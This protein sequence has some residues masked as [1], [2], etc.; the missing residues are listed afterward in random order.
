MN[1]ASFWQ[2]SAKRTWHAL[3]FAVLVV[4]GAER[5]AANAASAGTAV[6]IG[7]ALKAD[8]REVWSRLVALSGGTGSKWLVFP[9]AS[10]EPEQS[11]AAIIS[12]LE[13]HGATAVMVPLSARLKSHAVADVVRDARWIEQTRNATGVYFTGGAQE[14]ITTALYDA[15]GKR[16]PL[17][18]AIWELFERGGVVAGSS[19]GAAI[20]SETMFREPRDILTLMREG[21]KRGSDI[22]R[23]LGFVG[24]GVL[25]DQHFIKRGRFGRALAVMAQ[26]K[27]MLGIGVEENSAAVFKGG[28]VEVLGERGVMVADLTGATITAAPLRLTNAKLHWLESG[29][30]IDLKTRT[31]DVSTAKRAGN[32]L[33]AA[34]ANFKP[35]YNSVRFYPDMLGDGD[36]IN[37]MTTLVDSPAS[38]TR[39][40]AFSVV[41]SAAGVAAGDA[42]GFEFRLYKVAGTQ[43]AGTH[44]FFHS[45]GGGEHYSVINMGLDLMPIKMASPLYVPY[46]PP[47]GTNS[48][49]NKNFSRE[50]SP[51][52]TK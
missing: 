14:R 6:A 19:A 47:P 48:G 16:T 29:D 27:I 17:L 23:G 4:G 50:A 15:A 1:S 45:T 30:A 3:F 39:G 35:Y 20:M 24:A 49:E 37:A 34:A 42:L 12:S 9:T 38:E 46:V 28:R 40:I 43:A 36:V 7:G 41:K 22:D 11:A 21:A 25:V 8:N 13:K 2:E 32:K 52:V 10:G 5:A 33:D 31:I 51:M 18:E 26:E 44:G